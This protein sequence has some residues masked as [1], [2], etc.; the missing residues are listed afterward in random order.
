MHSARKI[1]HFWLNF[2]PN[3]LD[4]FPLSAWY[5]TLISNFCWTFKLFMY[6]LCVKYHPTFLI[7]ERV[8]VESTNKEFNRI[9]WNKNANCD[10]KSCSIL[11]FYNCK[12]W[13]WQALS[14]LNYFKWLSISFLELSSSGPR[15][16]QR[17]SFGAWLLPQ[18]A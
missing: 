1:F 14:L 13:V 11:N 12:R 3:N 5:L 10:T 15:T 16:T 17:C 8:V 4:S 9:N 18:M 6:N 2:W 7:K